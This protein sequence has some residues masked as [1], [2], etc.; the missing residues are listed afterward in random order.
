MKLFDI[1]DSHTSPL[2]MLLYFDISFEGKKIELFLFSP[3]LSSTL[4]N[5][6]SFKMIHFL[7]SPRATDGVKNYPAGK[8]KKKLVRS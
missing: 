5:V 6:D 8:E 2:V 7:D 3:S 1:T 4:G